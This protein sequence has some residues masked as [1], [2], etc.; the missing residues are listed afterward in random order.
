MLAG[1]ALQYPAG[2]LAD[3]LSAY[4][5]HMILAGGILSAI[6]M[7]LI[8]SLRSAWLVLI[9]MVSMGVLSAFARASAIAIR[10]ERGRTFGMGAVTG[11]STTSISIGQVLGPISFG[12]LYDLFGLNTSFIVGGVVGFA[13]ALLGF[14]FLER[15]IPVGEME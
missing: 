1:A 2:I 5:R 4:R 7:F 10:T 6:P 8:G 12:L 11:V 14:Y 9:L 13:G 15:N 3:R